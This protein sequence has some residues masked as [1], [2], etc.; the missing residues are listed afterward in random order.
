MTR[1]GETCDFESFLVYSE[2]PSFEDAVWNGCVKSN[3]AGIGSSKFYQF[4]AL[5]WK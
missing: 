4:E 5:I 3:R 1:D 2:G